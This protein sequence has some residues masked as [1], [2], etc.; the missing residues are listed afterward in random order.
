[1]NTKTLQVLEYSKIIDM[2]Q[3]EAGSALTRERIAEIVPMTDPYDIKD[4]LDETAEAV[5]L[6]TMKG[7]L[8]L[9]NFYD[10]AGPMNLARKGGTLTMAELLRIMYNLTAA[11]NVAQ[12]LKH[13]VPEIPLIQS[14]GEVI[15]VFRGLEDEIDRCILSEDE[16]S[17]T[18]SPELRD[19]RRKI[20]QK[21]EA[22]KVRMDHLVNS[23]STRVY[24]QDAI[25]TMRDGRYVVPVKAEHKSQIPGIVHD[26]SSSGQTLFIEP[27]TVVVLNNDLRQLEVDEQTEITR[28]LQELSSRAAEHYAG[29]MNNQELLVKLDLINAKGRLA[30]DMGAEKPTI[31]D[32][33]LQLRKA[34]HPLIDKKKVVPIDITIGYGGDSSL[35]QNRTTDGTSGWNALIITGPNTGGKTVT[36]KTCGLL[37]MMAQTG[38][39]IP[40]AEGSLV[41]IYEDIFADIGDEQ[42]IEQSLSTFSSHMTNIVKICE[43]A[44]PG[45]LVL[46]DEL[47]AGTDP[48]EGAAL[49]ISILEDLID[50]GAQVLATT[51]YTEL[52]K[53]AL[54]KP[55]VQNASMQFDVETLSP[56]YKLIVGIPG[57]SNAFEISK[58]LGLEPALIEKARQ[59]MESGEMEFED[60]IGAIEADRKA[61]EAER[62]EAALLNVEMKKLREEIAA[63]RRRIEKERDRILN[64]AREQA[65]A[66]VEEAEDF[67][68]DIKEELK[69]LAKLES[70]GERTRKFDNSR[71]KIKDA[72]GRYKE[73]HAKEI[74]DNPVRIEDLRVGDWVKVVTMQQ[75]GEVASLPD[76]KG[77]L[78]V[79]VGALKVKVKAEDLM[80]IP[81]G[82]AKKKAASLDNAKKNRSQYGSLYRSKSQSVSVQTD[83]R[84]QTA[85]EALDHVTKYLDDAF[86]AG[87][88]E[89]TVVHGRGE[90]ILM[91]T[92]RDELKRNKHVKGFR[93]GNYNEGGDGVTIVTLK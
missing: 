79:K 87:L 88:K 25:V 53:Y 34:R 76:N 48:L 20:A 70:M 35:A 6:I 60:V 73:K 23:Q 22:I 59:L 32:G 83:V 72:A 9:G 86:M 78:T 2:L 50:K 13:D 64:E 89:V 66:M 8:P 46:V 39:H 1:M 24:L 4:G 16:M 14:M 62:D 80:I 52:K 84:G 44:R 54:T 90:G 45:T 29:I 5:Q 18:A 42:S 81:D 92:I 41:P 11:R 31:S 55:G 38:L 36:L 82:R 26:Q 93:R 19:I 77:E 74:N 7:P 43:E 65:R 30:L 51:H 17:D 69:E 67:S 61:A 56:T 12:F 47:G 57:R 10:I 33:V 40:A 28:I 91:K 63:E 68:L 15:G 71:R 27:Q 58:K 21:S 3:A 49:A 37:A 75:N 85:E